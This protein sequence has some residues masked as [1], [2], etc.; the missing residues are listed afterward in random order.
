M[1]YHYSSYREKQA[2]LS[3]LWVFV[4]LNVL[5]RDV[6]EFLRPGVINEV[7]AGFLNGTALTEPLLLLGGMILEVQVAMVVLSRI[8]AE[9][10]NLWLNTVVA[11]LSILAILASEHQYLDDVFFATMVVLG[12]LSILWVI[13]TRPW[14]EELLRLLVSQS[15][16]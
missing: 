5:F 11:C 3:A 4:L 16:P 8:L 1:S 10:L 14:V 12:L 15:R 2:L 9:K 7:T 6:H 13:F